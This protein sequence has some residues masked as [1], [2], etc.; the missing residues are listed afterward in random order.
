M[1]NVHRVTNR[2]SK[3]LSFK[4]VV[5][6]IAKQP[7]LAKQQP[8]IM[9]SW[10]I[11]LDIKQTNN[12]LQGI[13]LY[14]KTF[15]SKYSLFETIWFHIFE[16]WWNCSISSFFI[17]YFCI[18]LWFYYI[19]HT[20]H[21]SYYNK[22]LLRRSMNRQNKKHSKYFKCFTYHH[23]RTLICIVPCIAKESLFDQPL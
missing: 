9:Y 18:I 14:Y 11:Y 4:I 13:M 5:L 8:M 10:Q 6:F 7:Y 3:Y 23:I 20:Y 16:E 22:I 21:S 15:P 19:I 1:Y 17:L 2:C 12:L